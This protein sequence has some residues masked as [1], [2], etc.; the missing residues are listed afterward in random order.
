MKS[1]HL[2]FRAEQ[3]DLRGTRRWPSGPE[4][5]VIRDLGLAERALQCVMPDK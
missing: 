4:H 2:S 3:D 1:R 5:V